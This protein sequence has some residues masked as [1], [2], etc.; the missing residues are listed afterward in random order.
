MTDRDCPAK[1]GGRPSNTRVDLSTKNEFGEV[2]LNKLV[3]VAEA[4]ELLHLG[5]SKVYEY[6]LSGSLRSVKLGRARRIPVAEI[7]QFVI[8]LIEGEENG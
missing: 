4:A 5:R 8:R 3:T 2:S 7:E 1:A 6:I